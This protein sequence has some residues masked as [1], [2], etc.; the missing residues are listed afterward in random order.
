[1]LETVPEGTGSARPALSAHGD[2]GL[3]TAAPGPAAA[4]DRKF[5]LLSLGTFV[6][7]G[8]PDGMLGTAWPA[9]RSSFGE[10]V[11]DL[12]LILLIS[13]VGSV[14]VAAV[15]GRL[16]RRLGA[17]AV[18]AVASSSAAL[19]AVGFAAAP[20]LWLV[21][22]VGPLVGAAAGMMDGGLNTV[23]ALMD[24]PRLLN[25]L[26]GFYGVGT[27]IGPLVV[28]GAI[29][30]GSWRPAYLV[31]AVLNVAAAAC[32]ILYRRGVPAPAPGSADGGAGT[33]SR[34]T[35]RSRRGGPPDRGLEPPARRRRA[36]AR[37]GRV[38]RVHRAGGE[39][40]PV[41]NQLRPRSP[42]P[43]GAGRRAG[44][45]RLLGRADR[46]P[47][48]PRPADP[49]SA[50]ASGHPVRSADQHRCLRDHLVAARSRRGSP[51]IRPARRL[52]R[53]RLPGPHRRHPAADRRGTSAARH[54]LAGRRRRCRR[55]GGLSAHRAADR[56]VQPGGARP[57][58][59]GALAHPRRRELGPGGAGTAPVRSK[60]PRR[61]P[62]RSAGSAT[63]PLSPI[64]ANGR[65]PCA[66]RTGG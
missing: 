14:A 44:R 29:L 11:G 65:R 38:L 23:V 24:R 40:G 13:T 51:R 12:G 16:I 6:V 27:A 59:R 33:P 25:L 15:V 3:V 66:R 32:W 62:Q 47:D 57:G 19:A 28:T 41:G 48:R 43:V 50:A 10:P 35:G 30:A 5:D 54:R 53:R 8:L 2:G 21:L 17:A 49:A 9:M 7:L 56:L 20:G 26:H 61:L 64:G 58:D 31:L 37:T 39:R 34:H 60:S 45:L 4:A 36:D 52:A 22:S 1:M 55:F 63:G 42:G 46:R 18:L